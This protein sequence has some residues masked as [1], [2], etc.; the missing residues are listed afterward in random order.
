MWDESTYPFPSLN[1]YTVEVWEW[2][3]SSQT[4]K[5]GYN[6]VSMVRLKLIH[7]SKRSHCWRGLCSFRPTSYHVLASR[8][9]SHF[10]AATYLTASW[11]FVSHSVMR[12]SGISSLLGC[13]E[14]HTVSLNFANSPWQGMSVSYLTWASWIFEIIWIKRSC[15][16]AWNHVLW[17]QGVW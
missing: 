8:T 4:L 5:N 11:I 6:Y 10:E 3:I 9:S 1:G 13:M 12:K 16:E 14:L 2:R 7:V 17:Y 15:P